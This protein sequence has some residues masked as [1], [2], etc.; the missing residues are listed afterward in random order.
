MKRLNSCKR[1][2]IQIFDKF[3]IILITNDKIL[4]KTN[5]IDIYFIVCFRGFGARKI[6]DCQ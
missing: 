5:L 1:L 6:I 2:L 4:F 3:G